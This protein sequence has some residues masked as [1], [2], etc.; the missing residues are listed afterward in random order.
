MDGEEVE[1]VVDAVAEQQQGDGGHRPH[2]LEEQRADSLLEGVDE[3]NR[4]DDAAKAE[5]NDDH[6][7]EQKPGEIGGHHEEGGGDEKVAEETKGVEIVTIEE[8]RTR[9]EDE[10]EAAQ[11]CASVQKEE[12]GGEEEKEEPEGPTTDTRGE[13]EAEVED[14][15]RKHEEVATAE[16]A[17]PAVEEPKQES[18]RCEEEKEEK[19]EERDEHETTEERRSEDEDEKEEEAEEERKRIEEEAKERRRQEEEEKERQRREA[20]AV[21]IE[22]VWRGWCVRRMHAKRRAAA[23]RIQARWRGCLARKAFKVRLYLPRA[24]QREVSL[25]TNPPRTLSA[26]AVEQSSPG[27][28]ETRRIGSSFARTWLRPCASV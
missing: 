21:L 12:V 24:S 28:A 8:E 17:G 23:V 14:L 18:R 13:A 10:D 11:D 3:K 7:L 25:L 20:A 22:R 27:Q 1:A 2:L 4:A 9:R 16:E 15:E 19:R 26:A 6:L 5:G